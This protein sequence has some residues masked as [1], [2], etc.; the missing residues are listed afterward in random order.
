[1]PALRRGS[2]Q[3]ALRAQ[4]RGVNRGRGVASGEPG[5]TGC[6][7]GGFTANEGRWRAGRV[8]S[9]VMWADSFLDRMNGTYRMSL[10]VD[11][12]DLPSLSSCRSCPKS[13]SLGWALL[14]R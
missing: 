13:L 14:Q 6:L 10:H 9:L 3:R 4:R 1:M 12:A 2:P 8:V 7:E 5:S 11:E